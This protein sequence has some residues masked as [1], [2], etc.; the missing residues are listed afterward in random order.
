[1]RIIIKLGTN[2]L[3]KGGDRLSRPQMI[4]YVRQIVALRD[5]G[6]EVLLVSSGAVFAG[7]EV[8]DSEPE[9]NDII[10]RQVLASIGQVRLMTI[11]QQ[12]FR[13][14]DTRVAQALLTRADLND[15]E[16]YLNARNT[17][18]SL[19]RL[20]IVPIVNENDV[21]ATDEIKIGDN[22]NL[23]ALV[24]NLVDADLLIILTDQAGLFTADP[25]KNPSAQLI[26]EVTRIDEKLRQRAG[27]GGSGIGTGGMATKVEAAEVSMRAGT[28][29][30]IASGHEPEVLIRLVDRREA[31]GTRFS[32]N[33]S[34]EESRKQWILSAEPM[35]QLV[36]DQGASHDVMRNDKH[37]YAMGILNVDGEFERG[38]TVRLKSANGNEFGRGLVNYSAE[39]LRAISGQHS[40]KIKSILGYEYGP[41]VVYHNELVILESVKE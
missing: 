33:A 39:D 17:L 26:R 9:R 5:A 31:I 36:L 20:N 10:F 29:V 2:I 19:L 1:M 21:V 15:R 28:D 13:L 30:I 41:V 32:S 25:R 7:R 6:H 8:M 38:Q 27:K 11:Y 40:S 14:Y 34:Q 23:S 12:L 16:H 24:G 18:L 3:T 35:G 37:L 22:D 4:E